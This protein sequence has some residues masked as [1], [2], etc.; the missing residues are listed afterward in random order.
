MGGQGLDGSAKG[1]P[2]QHQEGAHNVMPIYINAY[3][4]LIFYLRAFVDESTH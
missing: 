1:G 4:I 3:L 2:T